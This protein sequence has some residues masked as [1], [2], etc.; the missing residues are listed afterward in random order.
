MH[1]NAFR[2]ADYRNPVRLSAKFVYALS[3]SNDAVEGDAYAVG[4]FESHCQKTVAYT[5]CVRW[6]A[7]TGAIA[8]TPP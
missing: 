7:G 5:V 8:L 1:S 6:I 2:Q 4:Q 3:R